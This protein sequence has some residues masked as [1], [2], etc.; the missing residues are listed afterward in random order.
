MKIAIDGPVASGKTSTAKRIAADFC[1]PYIDT[2]AMFRSIALYCE[3]NNLDPLTDAS[4]CEDIQNNVGVAIRCGEMSTWMTGM[5]DIPD[6]LLR[7]QEVSQ[8]ASRLS[9]SQDIRQ[10]VSAMEHTIIVNNDDLI[11][12]GRDIGSVVLPNAGVKFYLDADV[13]IRTYRRRVDLRAQGSME[14]ELSIMQSIIDRDKRDKE[15]EIAPLRRVPDAIYID[16]T[17]L[18]FEETVAIMECLISRRR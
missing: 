17:N 7:T 14:P 11:M 18:T 1:I 16:N 5:D 8:Q 3:K 9:T 6:K 12:E 10:I 4:L 15:R 2:G 13:L